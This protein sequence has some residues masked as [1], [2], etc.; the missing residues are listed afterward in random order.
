MLNQ[1]QRQ[2]LSL[3]KSMSQRTKKECLEALEANFWDTSMAFEWIKKKDT[4]P[5]ASLEDF[6]SQYDIARSKAAVLP[7]D[8]YDIDN[9]NKGGATNRAARRAQKKNKKKAK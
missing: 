7:D 8:R 2:R 9:S 1:D 4:D 3:L 5:N 6:H